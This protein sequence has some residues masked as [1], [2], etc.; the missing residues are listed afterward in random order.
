MKIELTRLR[1]IPTAQPSYGRE[2]AVD[3][4]IG[5][6]I[7]GQSI[8]ARRGGIHLSYVHEVLRSMKRDLAN[9]YTKYVATK[10]GE[11]I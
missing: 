1:I 11:L 5:I 7:D 4:E 10:I 3:I 9:E 6:V 8:G 2:E